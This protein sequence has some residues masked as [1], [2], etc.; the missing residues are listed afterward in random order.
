MPLAPHPEYE[1]LQTSLHGGLQ[2][3]AWKGTCYRV[4]EER[5][6]RAHDL[7]TGEGARRAGGRWN[8]PGTAAAYASLELAAA[9][10]EWKAQQRRAGIPLEQ[11]M[12]A[13]VSSGEV[14]LQ[15][16]LDLADAALLR[17]LGL[18][19][20]KLL[21]TRWADE[22]AA[23][24]EGLTQAVG[25]AALAAGYEALIV[26]S[27]VARARN[28]VLFPQALRPGSGVAVRGVTRLVEP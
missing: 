19:R 15:Q 25:R 18:A 9:V 6:S 20:T 14:E 4:A 5:W 16:V 24:R 27:A 17:E 2:G 7:F 22:N 10:K 11:A 8:H 3:S 21:A 12:P 13:V 23:G 28:L 26:P 1:R